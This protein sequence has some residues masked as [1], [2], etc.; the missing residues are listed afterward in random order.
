MP[1]IYIVQC[2]HCTIVEAFN[3]MNELNLP[4][5]QSEKKVRMEKLRDLFTKLIL[6]ISLQL[7]YPCSYN[8]SRSLSLDFSFIILLAY[9]PGG[10]GG[11]AYC[12][13][14][15]WY[16]TNMSACHQGSPLLRKYNCQYSVFVCPMRQ[17][18]HLSHE[19]VSSSVPWGGV[20]VCPLR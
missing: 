3:R 4:H 16:L 8:I 14:N 9:S 7:T 15:I 11:M 17:W 5:K 6:Y 13:I 1:Y 19:A 10:G 18:P 12:G 20:L 2:V